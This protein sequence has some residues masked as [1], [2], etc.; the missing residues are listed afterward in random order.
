MFQLKYLAF[1]DVWIAY[2]FQSLLTDAVS[3]LE[4]IECV[5]DQTGL[6]LNVNDDAQ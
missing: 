4:N 3:F 1:E 6:F 2:F 5:H